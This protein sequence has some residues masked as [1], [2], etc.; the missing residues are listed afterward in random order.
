M[1]THSG[2]S[3]LHRV[4]VAPNP[5]PTADEV[6][7]RAKAHLNSPDRLR[8]KLAQLDEET[9]GRRRLA[10]EERRF[11]RLHRELAS[12]QPQGASMDIQELERSRD[13]SIDDL[14]R[15]VDH[16]SSIAGSSS[17]NVNDLRAARQRVQD[18][19][20]AADHAKDALEAAR[21]TPSRISVS[22]PDTYE[23]GGRSFLADLYASQLRSDPL[24]SERISKHQHFEMERIKSTRGEQFAVAT[25]TLGGIIPPQYMVDLYAKAQRFGRVFA[26]Q[27]RHEPLPDVGMS[28]IV[29]RLTQGLAAGIQTAESNAVSTQ[30]PT[31]TDLTINVRTVAGYSPV[32]R[33]TLERAAYSDTIL[34]ED[35][36]ARYFATLDTQL[37]S[38]SGSSGQHLGVINTAGVSSATVA[39]F[40]IANAWAAIAGE[41]GVLAAINQWAA[42]VGAAADKIFMHPRR[43]GAFLGLLDSSNRP[44]FGIGEA[45]YAPVGTGEASGYGIVGRMAGLPV[46]TD[47]NIPTNLGTGTNQDVILAIASPAVILWEREDDPV[48]LAFE[49]QAGTS[50]QV[51]LV[52]YGFSAFTAGR[53]P[54]AAGVISGAGLT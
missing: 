1:P 18:A 8:W 27:V 32:S 53:Y 15:A 39:S 22:E 33:Q 35:L 42:T 11:Q 49:Q 34:M 23:K 41:A 51:Q 10:S 20:E 44:L 37:I 47:A 45:N 2:F 5:E 12:L 30:D 54:A 28:V 16:F 52:C 7:T 31:E 4:Q 26:D 40:T 24:A 50:L 3:Y 38:G 19:E 6:W 43:W 46:Y 13:R 25:G 36:A 14:S 48:T 29:P 21:S 9:L 17:I